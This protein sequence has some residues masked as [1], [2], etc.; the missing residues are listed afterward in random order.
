MRWGQNPNANETKR[1]KG[2][3]RKKKNIKEITKKKQEQ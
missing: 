3:K 1:G 2:K